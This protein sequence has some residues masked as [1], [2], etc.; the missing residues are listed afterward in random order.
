MECLDCCVKESLR[1]YPTAP[2]T[3]RILGEDVEIDGKTIPAQTNVFLM[4]FLLHR[5]PKSFP[6]PD[7]FDPDRFSLDNQQERHAFSYV[8]FSAG[9]RNC[10]G[11]KFAKMEVKVLTSS[12]LRKYRLRSSMTVEEIPLCS[13]LTI[14]PK[15]GLRVAFTRRKKTCEG[16]SW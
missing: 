2:I 11:Q 16:R 7:R 1:L 14:K 6:D 13:E 5:D 12:I 8:P 3:S 9:P 15:H 4:Y 10:I